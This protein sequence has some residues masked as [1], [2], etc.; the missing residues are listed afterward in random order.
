VNQALL[1]RLLEDPYYRQP[2]PKSCGREQYGS[3]FLKTG[4]DVATATEFTART[5]AIAVERYPE[6]QEV[7]VS[8]G[9]A[10]NAYLMERL[11]ALVPA[12]VIPA[13]ALGVDVDAKE[14]VLFAVLA[15]E[16]WNRRPSNIPTAT[17]ARHPAVL[18]KLS[19]P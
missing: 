12:K 17:G 14:A 15:Y 3:E 6:T 8:G 19:L 5:I 16:T 13:T 7:I 18:G 10:H 2:P 4:I 11:R 9:G 1:G